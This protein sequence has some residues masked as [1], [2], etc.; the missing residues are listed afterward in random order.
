MADQ[1]K[2]TL[3]GTGT[4][5]GVPVIACDCKV[6]TSADPRDNR[7]RTSVLIEYRQQVL[8]ID[9][10]PDF[11]QQMLRQKVKK[12]DAVLF[13]HEHKDH[14]A[15]LDDV[16]AF[17][18]RQ[19]EAIDVYAEPRVQD[20]LRR[21][22]AYI[23]ADDRYP[24][25]PSVNMHLLENK[26]FQIGALTIQ[27]IRVMHYKLPILGFRIG[28]FAY[29][30]DVKSVPEEELSKL[31]GLEVLIVTALRKE[32]HISHMSLSEALEQVERI[33]PIQTYLTHLNHTF[34]LHAI[35]DAQLPKGVNIAYDGLEI[36][37]QL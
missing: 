23:F 18:F 26:P 11:R 9:T 34:G 25:I 36:L 31:A 20:A 13:T 16:R 12:L 19:K 6:C 8:V 2:F 29:L 37:Q 33:R 7:L 24:G 22:Y 17:N 27:P 28:N 10:G 30:T 35:E 4:S 1:I 3:L 21:E 32:P 14:V 15:G 5:Q